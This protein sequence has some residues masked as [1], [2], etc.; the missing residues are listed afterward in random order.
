MY[1]Y[2]TCVCYPGVHGRVRNPA[3]EIMLNAKVRIDGFY[4]DIPLAADD[5]FVK[6]LLPGDYDIT[7]GIPGN[8]LFNINPTF[9]QAAL[10]EAGCLLYST[11]SAAAAP[12]ICFRDS[13]QSI[14]FCFLILHIAITYHWGIVLVTF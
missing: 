11:R 3:G 14:S 9:N 6:L 4:S 5:S 13:Y 12:V 2:I 7:V 1:T 10:A 8:V